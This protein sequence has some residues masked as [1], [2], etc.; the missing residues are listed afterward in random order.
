MRKELKAPVRCAVVGYGAAHV[1]GRAHGRWIDATPGLKWA[2]VCDRDPERLKA[3]K[4]EFPQ[5]ETYSSLSEMLAKADIDMVSV[6]TPHHT[7]API[8]IECLNAGRHVVC[9]KAMC[10]TVAEADAMI[11]AAKK[12]DRTLAIFHARRHDGNFRAI[13]EAVHSG[14]IGDVFHIELTAG[15]FGKPREWWYAKKSLGGGAF[16]YW[17]PHA[18]D[19]VLDMVRQ[20]II[21]CNGFYHKLVWDDADQE[22]QAR[23]ILRFENGCVADITWSHI[24]AVGKPLW[25]VLGTQGGIIDTGAGGNKGYQELLTGPSGGSFQ[26]VTI[27]DGKRDETQVPYKESDWLTYYVDMANH[28]L[29]GGPV[30]VSGEDG[31]R[32][33]A[34]FEASERSSATGQT[35]PV[36]YE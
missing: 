26:M 35:E 31:R 14:R 28:L 1:F 15:G 19:W 21:G 32:T 4:D 36:A 25:R 22:D 20:K 11:A 2:A 29:H 33:I 8:S 30:P 17:G 12:N 13:K 5:L 18:I 23:A 16:Y 9:D 3:A 7:H 10:L 6:V 27:K 34:V 24:A